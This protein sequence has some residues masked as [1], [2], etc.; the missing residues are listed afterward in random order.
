MSESTRRV[1]A[2]RLEDIEAMQA[3]ERAAGRLFADVGM[4]AVA[5]DPP[6]MD[7]VLATYINGGR[8]WIAECDGRSVGYALADIVDGYG[9]LEQVSVHPAHGR[10]GLGRMLIHTVIEW[11]TARRFPALTLLTF[12]DVPWNRPY[13]AALGFHLL[14]EADWMPEL[15]ALRQHETE[16]GLDPEA[17]CAMYLKL[18]VKVSDAVAP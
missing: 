6:L 7:T 4:D 1:R 9:H 5:A 3:I 11:A 10:Q 14:P 8:A 2:A 18:P 16:R 15:T 17:R 13:Y 12:R